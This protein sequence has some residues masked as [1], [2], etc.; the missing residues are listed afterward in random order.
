VANLFLFDKDGTITET[1]SGNVCA[2]KKDDQIILP[3]VKET[4]S[5]LRGEG[6]SIGIITNQGGVSWGYMPE[7]EAWR[8]LL[9]CDNLL[10]NVVDNFQ[11]NFF[12]NKGILKSRYVNKAKPSPDMIFHALEDFKKA[13]K[14]FD[15]VWFVGDGFTDQ[16]AAQNF[17]AMQKSETSSRYD[18]SEVYFDF[19]HNFFNWEADDVEENNFGYR[20]KRDYILAMVSGRWKGYGK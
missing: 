13:G 18:T 3:N 1:I 6:H 11:V 9:H 7:V 8:I 5:R 14:K 12:Q 15:E 16:E 10:G 17:N 19:A 20:W 2:N 4:L